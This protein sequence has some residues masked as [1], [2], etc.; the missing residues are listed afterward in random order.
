[1]NAT[2]GN[3]IVRV[4]PNEKRQALIGGVEILT[5]RRYNHNFREKNPVVSFVEHGTEMVP[6]GTFLICNYNHFEDES[7]YYLYNGLYSIPLDEEV[8][9]RIK[10]DGSLIP[11][12]GNV[13]VERVLQQSIIELPPE[14]KKEYFDRG[15]VSQDVAGYDKGDFVFWLK[16]ADYEMVYMWK[17]VEKRAIKVH[18][19][20][21]IGYFKKSVIL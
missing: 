17:G 21:I 12:C 20:E 2:K 1:M 3:I 4:D 13:L 11:I 18:E 5:A 15:I 14:L 8:F 19:N 6:R 9:A 7:P 10:E 16:M